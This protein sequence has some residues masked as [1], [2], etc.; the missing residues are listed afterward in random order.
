MQSHIRFLHMF[1]FLGVVQSCLSTM[2]IECFQIQLSSKITNKG[3]CLNDCI[4]I[5]R[6]QKNSYSIIIVKMLTFSVLHVPRKN[7]SQTLF[8]QILCVFRRRH[9][10]FSLTGSRTVLGTFVFL[11][12]Y[13]S[14]SQTCT[15]K[16]THEQQQKVGKRNAGKGC[17]NTQKAFSCTSF[18]PYFCNCIMLFTD[19]F[20][21][22]VFSYFN[23]FFHT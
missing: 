8:R 18:S 13:L 3:E 15:H 2:K 9:Q 19:P 4:M 17:G 16:H 21:W 22:G 11:L 10:H 23:V 6:K 12:N 20:F 14:I 7:L 5:K 1:F